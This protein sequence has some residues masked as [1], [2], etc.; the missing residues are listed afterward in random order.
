MCL[1]LRLETSPVCCVK[2][3]KPYAT[4]AS[5]ASCENGTTASVPALALDGLRVSP[6]REPKP[7]PPARCLRAFRSLTA[8]LDAPPSSSSSSVCCFA[9]RGGSGDADPAGAE[10]VVEGGGVSSRWR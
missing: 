5:L 1:S 9:S 4:A 10:V 2:R 6:S 7:T 8:A 3:F